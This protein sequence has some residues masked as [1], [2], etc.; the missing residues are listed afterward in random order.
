MKCMTFLFAIVLLCSCTKQI[1][2]Q[3]PMEQV[4]VYYESEPSQ[5]VMF[6]PEQGIILLGAF[7]KEDKNIP[8]ME[9]FEKI[10]QKSHDIYGFSATLTEEFP[11]MD[12]LECYV[13][14]KIPLLVLQPPDR[15]NPFQQIWLEQAAEKVS[16]YRIP[17]LVDF[18]PNGADYSDAE[19][20]KKYYQ[21]AVEIF[22]EK[23]PNV[24]FILTM[25]IED[26]EKWQH[27]YTESADWLG[28]SIYENGG[29]QGKDIAQM[30]ER[31]YA[32]F[33]YEKPLMLSQVAISHYSETDSKYTEKEASD[34]IKRLYKSLEQYPQIK[35]V[36]YNSVN[37]TRQSTKKVEGQ[38][39]SIVENKR[40]LQTYQN[41]IQNVKSLMQKGKW[42][43]SFFKGY[44]KDGIV[45]IDKNTVLKE[46]KSD[47]SGNVILLE[48]REYIPIQN[49][50]G[51]YGEKKQNDVVFLYK[52]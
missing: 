32:I 34:E 16:Q 1:E 37:L 40:V 46:M 44:I 3:T 21:K 10:T 42:Y 50:Q 8:S 24:C 19:S 6:E 29:N 30:L 13:N 5:K 39:Y 45:Y 27:Y 12:I 47:Y 7:V 43:K 36:V 38:N 15:E 2:I 49:I 25:P 23:A 11:I 4:T 41:K 20:Y 17:L 33:Q 35:A 14:Q 18:Y 26:S 51:Y 52:Q 22:N 9:E 28:L 48:Q 31:W